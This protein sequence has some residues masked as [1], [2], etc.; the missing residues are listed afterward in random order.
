MQ[1]LS[2][3]LNKI[4]GNKKI[5][6]IVLVIAVLFLFYFIYKLYKSYKKQETEPVYISDPINGNTKLVITND[7]IPSSYGSLAYT[8]CVWVN[9][10]RSNYESLS[11]KSYKHILHRG[12]EDS[13]VAQPGIWLNSK[14]NNILIKYKIGKSGT[15]VLEEEDLLNETESMNPNMNLKDISESIEIKNIALNRWVHLC[16]VTQDNIV[17]AYVNGQ[18]VKTSV[19]ENSIEINNGDIYVGGNDK[20]TISGFSGK[21]TKLRYYGEAKNSTDIIKVYMEGP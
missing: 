6:S 16:L 20:S 19:S 15:C 10:D 14:K 8:I 2:G 9:I 11:D 5:L 3:S 18:L 4:K 1:K 12:D 7:S 17:Q 13:V 21:I